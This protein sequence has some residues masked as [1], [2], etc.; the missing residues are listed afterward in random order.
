MP[1]HWAS[2]DI[3]K[4]DFSQIRYYLSDG[5]RP[6]RSWDDVP[7]D[8]KRTFER[9]GVPEQERQFLAGVEA[10]YDSESAYSNMKEE[11]RTPGRHLRQLHGRPETP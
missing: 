2:P 11:L 10:Q 8:V 4:I 5:E 7:E 6:K 9:L 3:K 1:T